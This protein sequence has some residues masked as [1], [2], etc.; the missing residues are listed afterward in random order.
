MTYDVFTNPEENEEEK[1]ARLAAEAE[2][3]LDEEGNV[4]PKEPV[5]L[6]EVLP[7]S[8]LV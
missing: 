6:K 5:V 1:A 2:P 7:V 4:I 8:L 3:E